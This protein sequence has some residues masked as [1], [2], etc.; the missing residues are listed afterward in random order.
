M[1]H[2]EYL[3][4]S[5]INLEDRFFDSLREGY[6]GFNEWFEGKSGKGERA[7]VLFDDKESLDAFLYLKIEGHGED[8]SDITPP[9]TPKTRLKVGTFKANPHGT[10]LGERIIK[11]IMDHALEKSAEE[12]YV[13]VYEKHSDLT[14]L[15]QRFGFEL[16]GDQIKT[17]EKVYIKRFDNLTGHRYKDYPMVDLKS[18]KLWVLAIYPQFHSRMFP[19]SILNNENPYD[20]IQ[21]TTETN[22]ISKI[23]LTKMDCIAMM[24][25]GDVVMIYR[26]G[27]GVAPA[28]YRAVITSLCVVEEVRNIHNFT[29]EESFMN[30]CR[31]GS[32][33]DDNELKYFYRTKKYPQIIKMTYNLAMKKKVTNGDLIDHAGIQP[34][35]WGCFNITKPQ[36]KTI[37]QLG[38][39]NESL[40]F[41]KGW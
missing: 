38:Q 25:P 4:F 40:L 22:T 11:K 35:Y 21:D 3:P 16:W 2:L 15:L 6:N 18:A 33:F 39:V 29:S 34:Y 30:Y 23:Y 10:R 12:V 20:V 37:L 14:A 36:L 5:E 41:N 24:T 8:Y 9:F 32:V 13:T 17:G 28:R 7:Y 26:T 27:D 1:S 31:K 19:D